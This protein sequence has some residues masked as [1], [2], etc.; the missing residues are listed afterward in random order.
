MYIEKYWG[1][2][3][4]GSDDALSF[5]DYLEQKN[6][7]EISVKEIFEDLGLDTMEGNFRQ[8]EEPIVFE[9]GGLE[10]EIY[11]AIEVVTTLAALILE[12]KKTGYINLAE[13]GNASEDMNVKI[14]YTDA[15]LNVIKN[16]LADYVENANEYDIAE[17]MDE[18]ELDEIV[19]GCDM[20][21]KEL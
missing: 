19:E 3:V 10:A 7:S 5:M 4:G 8:S 16:A 20:L 15:E 11:Y 12:C 18:D 13:I 2:C 21:R 6:Q 1:E 17:M 9:L 14:T